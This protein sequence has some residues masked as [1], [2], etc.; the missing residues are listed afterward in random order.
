M[1]VEYGYDYDDLMLVPQPSSVNHRGEV[2]LS[3]DFGAFKLNIPIFGSPMR[4]I[5]SVDMITELGRLGG[6]GILHRFYT[7]DQERYMDTNFL[8]HR[9]EEINCN[10]GVAVGLNDMFYKAGLVAG[11]SVI[12]VDI[13]NGY[14]E[15]L[16]KF[17][18]EIASYIQKNNYKALLMAGNI[19]TLEGVAGLSDSGVSIIRIGIGSGQQCTTRKETGVG[20][21][22]LS[23]I[24]DCKGYDYSYNR[25]ITYR[26]YLVADGGINNSGRAVKSLAIGADVVMIGSLFGRCF[27]AEHD[28]KIFGMASEK[29]QR[30]VYGYTGSIEGIETTIKKDISLEN[31]LNTFTKNMRSAFTLQG[32]RN[33]T[34]LQKNAKWVEVTR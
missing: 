6:M 27:E 13:A 33:I 5:M 34:E 21:P 24:D 29:N 3:V 15:S 25:M 4:G 7:N 30:E 16:R 32:V 17:C 23:A 26:P 14:L 19:V 1:L 28:G 9:C 2:D 10:F 20:Y 22:Q 31:L 12:L 8:S 18:E 11:A